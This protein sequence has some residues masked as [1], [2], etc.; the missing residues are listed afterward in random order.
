MA[1]GILGRKVGM[2]QIFD[3]ETGVVVPVTVIEAGPCTVL[4]VKTVET[5]GYN[6][7][8][9]GF[10]EKKEKRTPKAMK[11]HFGKTGS[12]PKRFVREIRTAGKPEIEAG[13]AISVNALEGVKKV[14]VRGVSKGKGWAGVMKRWNFRGQGASHG[15]TLHHRHP[16]SLGRSYS[17]HKG[18]PK[19]MPMAGH[20][21]NENV[22]MRG[23]KL[24]KIISEDNLLVV[25]GAV[26]GPNGAYLVIRQSQKDPA[27]KP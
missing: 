9:L 24:V 16:G 13:A 4:Q 1:V 8:Q 18:V 19:G 21:G 12:S 23:L 15:N 2:T 5:D 26:P 17:V 14:D 22:T 6:A 27:Y 3:E 7:V 25:R 11:G 20:L 10:D